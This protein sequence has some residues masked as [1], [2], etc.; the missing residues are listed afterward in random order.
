M[1]SFV[2]HRFAQI[3]LSAKICV[4]CGFGCVCVNPLNPSLVCVHRRPFAVAC[5]LFPNPVH[6]VHPCGFPGSLHFKF[7]RSLF[8]IRYSVAPFPVPRS[9]AWPS[10]LH[11]KE[12]G[13]LARPLVCVLFLVNPTKLLCDGASVLLRLVGRDRQRAGCIHILPRTIHRRCRL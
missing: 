12:A 1:D 4:I 11:K 3:C 10:S 5:F 7:R 9:R 13:H 6:P 8:D 2:V